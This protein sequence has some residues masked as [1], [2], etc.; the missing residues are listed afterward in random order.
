MAKYHL[1]GQLIQTK[2]REC[3]SLLIDV[4]G[5]ITLSLVRNKCTISSPNFHTALEQFSLIFRVQ[6]VIAVIGYDASTSTRIP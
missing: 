5:D 1:L 3:G 2:E 6:A 4:E